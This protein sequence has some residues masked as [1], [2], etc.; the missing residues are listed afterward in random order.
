MTARWV[1]AMTHCSSCDQP[2]PLNAVVGETICPHCEKKVSVSAELW[3]AL[4]TAASGKRAVI[5]SS[6]ATWSVEFDS[7][8]EAKCGACE[9]AYSVRDLVARA[10]NGKAA[11]ASCGTPIV[12]R[13][14]PRDLLTRISEDVHHLVGE[15]TATLDGRLPPAIKA[16]A[17]TVHCQTCGGKIAADGS[18]RTATCPFCNERN[19]LSDAIWNRF[20]PTPTKHRFYYE[21]DDE[22]IARREREQATAT[23]VRAR[24]SAPGCAIALLLPTVALVVVGHYELARTEAVAYGALALAFVMSIFLMR[25][26]REAIGGAEE[27]APVFAQMGL[28]VVLALVGV[29]LHFAA[30]WGWFVAGVGAALAAGPI[31]E[32]VSEVTSKD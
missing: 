18:S 26:V 22:V 12:V 27:G 19:V 14:V 9:A 8:G 2:V 10:E 3:D 28:G 29:V 4:T 30:H 31:F 20:H 5:M 25:Q 15:D 23:E 17:V 32:I 21:V 13:P 24:Q 16:E 11:C 6:S 1:E 7:I